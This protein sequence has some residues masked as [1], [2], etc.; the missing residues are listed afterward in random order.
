MTMFGTIIVYGHFVLENG[1][2]HQN[3]MEVVT[4]AIS[5]TLD[6]VNY[7]IIN[8]MSLTNIKGLAFPN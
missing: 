1:Y 8:F 2:L 4:N 3:A 5:N 6:F 7:K